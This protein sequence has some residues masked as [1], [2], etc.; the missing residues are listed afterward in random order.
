MRGNIAANTG[1]HIGRPRSALA[2]AIL[3]DPPFLVPG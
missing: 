1:V 2:K 3:L